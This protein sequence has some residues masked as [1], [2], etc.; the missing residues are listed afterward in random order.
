VSGTTR[1]DLCIY[2]QAGA[3]VAELTVDRAGQTCGTRPC[4]RALGTTGYRYTDNTA[5]ADGFKSITAKSG[6]AGKGSVK[7]KAANRSSKG[8]T[9]L[10]TGIAAALDT[11]NAQATMQ[12]VTDDAGCF[13]AV[14]TTVRKSTPE[15]FAAKRP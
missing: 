14:L 3:L 15:E 9:S 8:Q 13:D 4:W 2:N 11:S 1:Y 7:L 12:V 6:V 5:S 10:P